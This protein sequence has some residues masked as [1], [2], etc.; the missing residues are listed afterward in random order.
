M[1]APLPPYVPWEYRNC[2]HSEIP[3]PYKS[4]IDAWVGLTTAQYY[5]HAKAA[6][7]GMLIAFATVVLIVLIADFLWT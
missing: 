4:Q 6:K 2:K 5:A 1:R 3:E 7:N